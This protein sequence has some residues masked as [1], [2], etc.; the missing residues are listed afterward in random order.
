MNRFLRMGG[1]AAAVGRGLL[2]RTRR[3]QL[4]LRLQEYMQEEAFFG[5]ISRSRT[6]RCR[7]ASQVAENVFPEGLLVTTST[8][9]YLLAAGFWTRLLATPGYGVATDGAGT[10]LPSARP[11]T[12]PLWCVVTSLLGIT[13]SL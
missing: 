12:R 9:L 11:R 4:A 8:G 3:R 6:Y 5:E 13:Q 2:Y 10:F 7:A 1:L